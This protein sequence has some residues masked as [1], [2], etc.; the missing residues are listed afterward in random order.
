MSES[1]V[2]PEPTVAETPAAETHVAPSDTPLVPVEPKSTGRRV[3]SDAAKRGRAAAAK[4]KATGSKPAAKRAPKVAT[5]ASTSKPKATGPV[6]KHPFQGSGC[7][8]I[9][10]TPGNAT[11]GKV[12]FVSDSGY[13]DESMTQAIAAGK[14]TQEQV[15]SGA[16]YVAPVRNLWQRV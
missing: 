2:T 3:Q 4:V 5:P 10:G 7:L 16:A 15:D 14:L 6:R 12:V 9:V 13:I 11:T 1:T 8:V